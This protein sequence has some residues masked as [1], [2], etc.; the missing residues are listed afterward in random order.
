MVTKFV[1]FDLGGVV[2]KDFSGT[3]KWQEM[4]NAVGISTEQNSRFNT[5]YDQAER[6]LSEGKINLPLQFE[7]INLTLDDFV[8]RFET[9]PSIWPVINAFHQKFPVGLLTNMYP[10]MFEAVKNRGLLPDVS[11]N[12]IIDSS[13]EKVAKPDPNIYKLAQDRVHAN[14]SEILFIENTPGNIKPARSLDWQTFLY[15][16]AHPTD[17]SQKLSLLL[18]TE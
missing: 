6:D 11:W 16:S 5:W 18:E 15:D 12:I 4:K 8:S 2:I 9:N 14:G 7:N 17:S 3:N 1:F 13:I 10:S